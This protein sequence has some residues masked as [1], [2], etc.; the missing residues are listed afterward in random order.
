MLTSAL[1]RTGILHCIDHKFKSGDQESLLTWN[2]SELYS[3]QLVHVKTI[4]SLLA[5]LDNGNERPTS[6]CWW[7]D[8]LSA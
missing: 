3:F 2:N 7:G 6:D 1:E 4:H 5:Y 8:A